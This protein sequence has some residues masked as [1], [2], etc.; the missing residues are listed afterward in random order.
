MVF[1]RRRVYA[2]KF[3]L[4]LVA[5]LVS[6]PLCPPR[7]HLILSM[8]CSSFSPLFSTTF[9]GHFTT[10]AYL[11]IG[12]KCTP[13]SCIPSSGPDRSGDLF[14]IRSPGPAC[15]DSSKLSFEKDTGGVSEGLTASGGEAASI[16]QRYLLR[17]CRGNP[18]TPYAACGRII[19]WCW[20]QRR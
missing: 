3:C 19:L 12:S 16:A 15:P 13:W 11:R 8:I 1:F 4:L 6:H 18:L 20:P 17:A 7:T 5:V 9:G 2:Y 10:S 14:L